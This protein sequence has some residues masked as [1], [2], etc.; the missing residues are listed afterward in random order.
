VGAG[1]ASTPAAGF[2]RERTPCRS[3]AVPRLAE[4]H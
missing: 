4:R 1:K 3:G 2:C